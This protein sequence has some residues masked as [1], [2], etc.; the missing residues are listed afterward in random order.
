MYNAIHLLM[1]AISEPGDTDL[2]R[3][4]SHDNERLMDAHSELSLQF[5]WRIWNNID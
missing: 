4:Y 2:Y 3:E 5:Q 1:H